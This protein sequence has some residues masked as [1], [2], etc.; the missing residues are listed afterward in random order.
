MTEKTGNIG[1]LEAVILAGGKGTRLYPYTSDIP[2]PLVPIAGR[3][4][5]EFLL[6]RLAQSGVTRVHLAV[7]HLSSMISAALGDGARWGMKIEYVAEN[8]PLSTIGPLALIQDLPD[9]FV[10]ANGDIITDLDVRQLMEAHRANGAELTVATH[11]RVERVDFGVIETDAKGNVVGFR[12]KPS[13]EFAVS[14]GIYAL[15][16]KVLNVIPSGTPFGFDELIL[17]LLQ[18]KA[19]VCA[20][21]YSGYWLDV[22]RPDDYERACREVNL[23]GEKR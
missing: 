7:N 21:P 23:F 20:F 2:K 10:V 4:V 14:M 18:S 17:N 1:P 11:H 12:E 5:I 8:R 6:D 3:P 15:S 19:K 16:K 22:G 9:H 13:Y